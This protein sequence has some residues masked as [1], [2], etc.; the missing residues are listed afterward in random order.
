VAYLNFLS[1]LHWMIFSFFSVSLSQSSASIG[2]EAHVNANDLVFRNSARLTPLP[3]SSLSSLCQEMVHKLNLYFLV[4][5]CSS[6]SCM[7]CMKLC[8]EMGRIWDDVYPLAAASPSSF[9][10]AC[11]ANLLGLVYTPYT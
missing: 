4:L 3:P 5:F 8:C 6:T 1:L 10:L 2:S 9:C 11:R 7:H